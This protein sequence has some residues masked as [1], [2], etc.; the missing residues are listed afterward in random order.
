MKAAYEFTQ[1]SAGVFRKNI[2]DVA[3]NLLTK[4]L[5]QHFLIDQR[6]VYPKGFY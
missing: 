4:K 6:V 2:V 1:Q 5:F 3:M